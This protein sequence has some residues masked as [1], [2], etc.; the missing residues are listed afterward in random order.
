MRRYRKTF[1]KPFFEGDG[2][3]LDTHIF[4]WF[5]SGDTRLPTTGVTASV[6]RG[7]PST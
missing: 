5:I 1:C 7:T 6:T 2:F 3:P 4:L